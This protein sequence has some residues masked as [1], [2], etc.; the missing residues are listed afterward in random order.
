MEY[1]LSADALISLLTLTILEI[2]LG[3]DNVIFVSIIMGR[4]EKAKQVTARR[5]WMLTGI[6]V[7]VILLLSLTWLVKNGSSE[8]FSIMGK[9]FNLRGLIMLAGGLFLLVKTVSEIHQ[10]LEGLEHGVKT[11]SKGA[12]LMQVVVQMMLVDMVFSFD[13]IITAV[14]MAQ[15][16]EVMI[17]AVIIAMFVMFVYA[18]KI[19]AFIEKHPT[20]KMLAL[21]FLVM[22]GVVLLIEGWDAD[23]AHDLHLKNYVYFAMA[24]SFAVELLNMQLRKKS[25]TPVVQLHEPDLDDSMK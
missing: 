3:V 19:S 25:T 12:T 8:L 23:K 15:H 10:K 20:V 4:L 14:G 21:S 5:I 11:N 2:V 1:L 13:S 9:S 18:G 22:I 17:I 6:V 7:R 16:V 24:F